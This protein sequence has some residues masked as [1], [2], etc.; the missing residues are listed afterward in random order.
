MP[1]GEATKGDENLK[2]T[3][4]FTI[5]FAMLSSMNIST[6]AAQSNEP[7]V[8]FDQKIEGMDST[9]DHLVETEQIYGG[10]EGTLM[11]TAS[12]M[13][14]SKAPTLQ[15]FTTGAAE[16]ENFAI[17]VS[18]GVVMG[19]ENGSTKE[20]LQSKVVLM[21]CKTGVRKTLP[22]NGARNMCYDGDA[23]DDNGFQEG[24]ALVYKADQFPNAPKESR[25]WNGY[26]YTFINAQG[27]ALAAPV[28]S[29]ATSFNK[30]LAG[31][32]YYEG[33]QCYSGV[34]TN[35]GK[36]K[37]AI[38]GAYTIHVGNDYVRFFDGQQTFCYDF[39]G[40]RVYLTETEQKERDSVNY[41]HKERNDFYKKYADKYDTIQYCGSNR[42]IVNGNA[43]VDS[44]NKTIIPASSL[45]SDTITN[46]NKLYFLTFNKGLCNKDGKTILKEKQDRIIPV[47]GGYFLGIINNNK[48]ILVDSNGKV[49]AKSSSDP[50]VVLSSTR[51]EMLVG[52]I[53]P[54]EY[55][56]N[57][58]A[59]FYTDT[60]LS[61]SSGTGAVKELLA[62]ARKITDFGNEKLEKSAQDTAKR[63]SQK[64]TCRNVEMFGVI[65][66]LTYDQK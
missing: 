52:Y 5:I 55:R 30:G 28:F 45:V 47:D 29:Y 58:K 54:H 23:Y 20:K 11:R 50:I 7:T 17:S 42:F 65:S 22:Y 46:G 35:K 62:N 6:A 44:E 13:K 61:K 3:I 38:F 43:V 18:D 34:L 9:L 12:L 41:N 33:D 59:Y 4:I 63:I 31:V 19:M 56:P 40:K 39:N 10:S 21:D 48:Q 1:K 24:W 27:K 25:A 57:A 49:I 15:T 32:R 36:I 37:F 2:K 14:A 51:V 53:Y 26:G 64:S 16:F 8:I 66:A 60:D